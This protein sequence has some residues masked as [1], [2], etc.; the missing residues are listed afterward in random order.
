MIAPSV[1]FI[2]ILRGVR[3]VSFVHGTMKEGG[4]V[5]AFD[6]KSGGYMT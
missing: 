4:S 1:Y 2:Q 3:L 6:R 5:K